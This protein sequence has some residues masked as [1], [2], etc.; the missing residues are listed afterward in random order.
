MSATELLSSMTKTLS[1]LAPMRPQFSITAFL[2]AFGLVNDDLM[3][4]FSEEWEIIIGWHQNPIQITDLYSIIYIDYP[5]SLPKLR[6][7]IITSGKR[8]FPSTA[9]SRNFKVSSRAVLP[10]TT[11]KPVDRAMSCA[12]RR[13]LQV[14]IEDQKRFHR[15]EFFRPHFEKEHASNSSKDRP[16]ELGAHT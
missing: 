8:H 11:V 13:S 14:I 7:T 16:S 5:V 4:I 2:S 1:F 12:S 10:S 3:L 15:R 9:T 6:S